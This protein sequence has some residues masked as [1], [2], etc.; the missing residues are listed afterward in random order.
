[1]TSVVDICNLAL[2]EMGNRVKIN[3]LLDNT[4]AA[5]AASIFYTPKTQMVLRAAPWDSA[6]TTVALTLLKSAIVASTGQPSPTPPPQPFLYEYAWPSDCLKAQFLIPYL[7]PQ[8]VGTPMTTQPNVVPY[9][10]NPPTRIP[11][12]VGRDLDASGNPIKV[13]LT[14][15][16]QAQLVYVA[17]ISQFPDLWDPLLQAAVCSVLATY[18]INDLA[19]DQAQLNTQIGV[20]KG[21]LDAARMANANESITNIDHLPDFIA[22]RFVGSIPWAL[23]GWGPNGVAMGGGWDSCQM[24]GGLSY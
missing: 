21:A 1:M 12:V 7:P 4:A 11:F 8:P 16:N 22:V 9:G 13:I 18:F 19:R 10:G 5:K 2:G 24:A 23:N 6:R 14:N 3:S 15:L 20:A 17:D